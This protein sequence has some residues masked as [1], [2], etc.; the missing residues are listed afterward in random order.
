MDGLTDAGMMCVMIFSY[1]HSHTLARLE[2]AIGL[3][4]AVLHSWRER[5]QKVEIQKEVVGKWYDVNR[6]YG[7]LE[8][9]VELK[10]ESTFTNDMIDVHRKRAME[11]YVGRVCL[12]NARY[13][14]CYRLPRPFRGVDVGG[15][16]IPKV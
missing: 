11:V 16:Y 9:S 4:D 7:L 10:L 6:L 14:R 1:L 15:W 13:N 12:R 3:Q 5:L 8:R 2:C